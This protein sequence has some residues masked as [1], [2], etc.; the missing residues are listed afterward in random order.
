[1]STS[2]DESSKIRK[3]ALRQLAREERTAYRNLYA[4]IAPGAGRPDLIRGQAMTQLRYQF[5]DRYLELYALERA[6]PGVSIPADI[7]SKSWERAMGI[8]ADLRKAPYRKHFD[9]LR[10]EGRSR[11]AAF[12]LATAELRAAEPDLFASLLAREISM[13]LT[14]GSGS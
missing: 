8:L 14:G 3:R 2:G 1:M 12:D 5:P 9:Q 10:S 4:T 6:A 11:A 13:W 7:R